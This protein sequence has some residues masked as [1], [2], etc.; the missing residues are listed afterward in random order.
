[1]GT[2]I[3]LQPK[4]AKGTSKLHV[5]KKGDEVYRIAQRY[6]IKLKNIYKRNNWSV[7]HIPKAG[8]TIY[9]RGRK[10]DL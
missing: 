1:M 8:D 2:Y 7:G 10:K 3:Y 9:L 4:K 6:G 5:F